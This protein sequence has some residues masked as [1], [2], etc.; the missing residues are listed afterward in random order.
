MPTGPVRTEPEID[1]AVLQ[2]GRHQHRDA[3]AGQDR[4]QAVERLA[5][6]LAG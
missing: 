3:H 2:F 1:I 5:E 6:I 4:D